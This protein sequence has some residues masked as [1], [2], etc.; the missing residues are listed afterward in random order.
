MEP[1]HISYKTDCCLFGA[2]PQNLSYQSINIDWRTCE[3]HWADET[4]V[5]SSSHTFYDVMEK[6]CNSAIQSR[7]EYD[8]G[9]E[10]H[11]WNIK[12]RT[13]DEIMNPPS[14]EQRLMRLLARDNGNNDDDDSDIAMMIMRTSIGEISPF[15]VPPRLNGKDMKTMT[16]QKCRYSIPTPT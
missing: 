13:M 1:L 16:I 2:H 6:L 4:I 8:H 14:P 15:N 3:P 10:E 5:A 11:L 7:R 9:V 12:I